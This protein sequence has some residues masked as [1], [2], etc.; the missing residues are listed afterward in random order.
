[1]NNGLEMF[2]SKWEMDRAR[3]SY[4]ALMDLYDRQ[5]KK[6]FYLEKINENLSW[7]TNDWSKELKKI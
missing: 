2:S 7:D 1:M 4:E 3:F 6:D 5:E